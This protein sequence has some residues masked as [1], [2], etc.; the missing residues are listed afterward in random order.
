MAERIGSA[1]VTV[2][3]RSNGA[4]DL[5]GSFRAQKK[6]LNKVGKD[7]S[8]EVGKGFD[9]GWDQRMRDRFNNDEAA[10]RRY[11]S[12]RK[13]QITK[14][15]NEIGK[16]WD[17]YWKQQAEEGTG[18]VQDVIRRSEELRREVDR[19]TT[20]WG[21]L[22]TAFSRLGEPFTKFSRGVRAEF[23]YLTRGVDGVV[24][25][26][27]DKLPNAFGPLDRIVT[28]SEEDMRRWR[29][30]L[31]KIPAVFPA[32]SKAVGDL[33]GWITGLGTSYRE[34]IL[35]TEN[36]GRRLQK[37]GGFLFSTGRL[38][39]SWGD[40]FSSIF[41]RR[42]GW[43]VAASQ[44]FRAPI[45]GAAR[46][47][48]WSGKLFGLLSGQGVQAFTD[49]EKAASAAGTELEN[50]GNG[51]S[52]AAAGIAEAGAA[53][54]PAAIAI[55]V[56]LAGA[57]Q[58][59]AAGAMLLLGAII[60]VSSALSFAL[61]GG[62]AAV[63]VAL[64]PLGAAFG[65][66]L[67]ALSNMD[68]KTKK[69]F[70]GIKT[71]FGNLG[72][73][74]SAEL[75][76]NASTDADKLSSSLQSLTPVV[77]EVA[78]WLRGMAESLL[79]ALNGPGGQAFLKFLGVEIPKLLKPI[80]Q[81]AKD[82]GTF[83]ADMFVAAAPLAEHFLGWLAGIAGSLADLGK[84]GSGSK[85]AKFFDSAW[86]SVKQVGDAIGQVI[87]LLADLLFNKDAQKAG[88][89]IFGSLAD[90]VKKFRD[91]LTSPEGK[92]AMHDLV[93]DGEKL[94]AA[95]GSAFV[96]VGKFIGALDTPETRTVVL[97]L[98]RGFAR[99]VTLIAEQI[100]ALGRFQHWLITIAGKVGKLKG[101]FE[102]AW[103]AITNA[104]NRATAAVG[105]KI[106]DLV[107]GAGRVARSIGHFFAQMASDIGTW[108][109]HM[110]SR[111]AS[112]W[113]TAVS[114]IKSG[115][116]NAASWVSNKISDIVNWFQSL[117]GKITSIDWGHV[118][119]TV[120]DAIYNAIINAVTGLPGQIV[121][122]FAHLGQDILNA[123]G[124]INV[125][126]LIHGPAALLHRIGLASGGLVVG[127]QMRLIGE[128]GPE[129]V[130]PLS[131]PL[132][133]V[134]PAVRALSAI[135]Q[136]KAL[137][138]VATVDSGRR[139]DV[140][141]ITVITPVKDPAAVAQQVVNRIAAVSYI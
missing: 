131:R 121:S 6:D 21:R 99:I 100:G 87:V 7:M 141:G 93:R 116:S 138:G 22:R 19:Q 103:H 119:S 136:G 72:K 37:F 86:K 92:K 59:A 11:G 115:I 113:N 55:G 31:R 66:A 3:F 120:G 85:L 30:T 13:T 33:G 78:A 54:G 5:A 68:A 114:S 41:G 126:S 76:K 73:V 82:V 89:Q 17:R 60:A 44:I 124:S 24:Q 28:Q 135:A 56:L 16:I 23:I 4:D 139:I 111:I 95:L 75:F 109:Q 35:N 132:N 25:N 133:Q 110:G 12:Q 105:Q 102:T 108:F 81:I 96:A 49:V 58:L 101:A 43:A 117:P 15:T 8:D 20:V 125:G 70:T 26:V 32:I 39:N 69:A 71:Q 128:A 118:G 88:D 46:L 2:H 42:S 61:V 67:L 51:A 47:F 91:Y 53:S 64:V 38:L 106:A 122:M 83:L 97:F 65:V 14:I 90:N 130:V 57:F 137:G 48:E 127:P 27:K 40:S 84:G 80:G 62:I 45:E 63:A 104:G 29:E 50:A 10:W 140:G 79:D 34:W 74:A 129:A 98:L 1:Y 52:G 134:D 94:A 18:S 9:D 112:I 123:I 107:N 36:L 77:R